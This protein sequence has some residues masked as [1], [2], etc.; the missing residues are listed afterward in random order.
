[1]KLKMTRVTPTPLLC[2]FVLMCL[3]L[4][5]V[6]P[7]RAQ[8]TQALYDSLVA[9]ANTL[10]K[11]GKLAEAVAAATEATKAEPK[12]FEAFALTALVLHQQGRGAE[13]QEFIGKALAL[14]P[15]DKKPRLQDMAKAMTP[16]PAKPAETKAMDAEGRLKLDMLMLVAQDADRARAPE[17]R[18]RAL[19][20]FLSKSIPFV[21]AYPTE[22]GVWAL[23][24]TAAIEMDY[25]RS[26]RLAA[27]KLKAL[28]GLE[29]DDAKLRL[30]LASL[31]Q[32]GWLTTNSASGPEVILEFV[33]DGQII[34][35]PAVGAD[36]TIYVASWASA[37]GKTDGGKVFA[38][39]RTTGEPK[40]AFQTG[41]PIYSSPVVGPAGLVCFGSADKKLYA[42]NIQTGEKV[43]SFAFGEKIPADSLTNNIVAVSLGR[44]GAIFT[45]MMGS[46][47]IYGIN[48]ETSSVRWQTLVDKNF[49][50]SQ[51]LA[52]DNGDNIYLKVM[53]SDACFVLSGKTGKKLW[54]SSSGTRMSINGTTI[55]APITSISLRSD[56]SLLFGTASGLCA[57]SSK[58]GKNSW[59][60]L[61][62]QSFVGAAVDADDSIYATSNGYWSGNKLERIQPAN[63]LE[64][65]DA[66]E[67][68]GCD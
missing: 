5:P 2:I 52:I 58:N 51:A 32:K 64:E 56:G 13:A 45:C 19:R 50:M 44:D 59:K 62:G 39:N 1:M 12:R 14:A 34:G 43:S 30:I 16:T 33:A 37:Q 67:V 66:G 57:A 17:E 10:L 21:K 26:G 48:A 27:Q 20:E 11:E 42:V 63:P 29:S 49:S 55:D 9:K 38:L 3:C 46:K 40:W 36:G 31:S 4:S 35:A 18:K 24:A 53:G 23:R 47:V 8:D 25:E 6:Q 68:C 28:V 65:A 22:V 54:A 7:V 61:E 15:E 60:S 41:G